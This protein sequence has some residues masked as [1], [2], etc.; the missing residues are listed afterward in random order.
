[1][2][3]GPVVRTEAPLKAKPDR[4]HV[5]VPT[6]H[7]EPGSL[8]GTAVLYILRRRMPLL[9]ASIVLVPLLTYIAVGQ[10]T[11]MYSA[12]GTLLYDDS[13]YKAQELQSILQVD[14]ITEAVMVTQAEVLRG[15]PIVE[16]VASRLNLYANPEFNASLRPVS[17]WRRPL[18]AMAHMF[19]Q[20]ADPV[21]ERATPR[22]CQKRNAERCARGTHRYPRESFSCA[23]SFVLGNRSGVGR[24]RGQ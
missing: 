10:L 8:S 4:P 21:A 22:S 9:L 18:S 6:E 15:M 13:G 5:R 7:S 2:L 24:R 1:M 23:G 17:W 11:P 20:T 19:R 14:P 16:Q 3:D 12:T